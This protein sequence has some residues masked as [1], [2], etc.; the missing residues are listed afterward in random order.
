MKWGHFAVVANDVLV[1]LGLQMQGD[2]KLVVGPQNFIDALHLTDSI[3]TNLCVTTRNDQ[4]GIGIR[5]PDFVNG[6]PAF[7]IGIVGYG[8]G[9]DDANIGCF[10]LLCLAKSLLDEQ[11][12]NVRRFGKVKFASQSIKSECSGRT[13]RY[14]VFFKG[15]K[16]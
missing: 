14:C 3:G 12:A 9:V 4:I 11:L 1:I 13:H 5:T 2:F 7:F 15:N 6:L 16:G 8:A 10:S